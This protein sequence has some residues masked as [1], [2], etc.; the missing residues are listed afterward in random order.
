MNKQY[1]YLIVGAGIYGASLHVWLIAM[2]NDVWSSTNVTIWAVISIVKTSRVSMSI[3][4][5]TTR[6]GLSL[7]KLFPLSGD[8]VDVKSLGNCDGLVRFLLP[9]QVGGVFPGAGLILEY[10]HF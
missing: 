2:A 8:L 7:N 9:V 3:T 10:P 5:P 4:L 1:D 6:A